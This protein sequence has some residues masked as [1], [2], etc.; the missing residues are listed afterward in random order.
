MG[1]QGWNKILLSNVYFRR[2]ILI[3]TPTCMMWAFTADKN[4]TNW[5]LLSVKDV[6]CRKFVRS[7]LSMGDPKRRWF[8]VIDWKTNVKSYSG[9]Y[10]PLANRSGFVLTNTRL[11]SVNELKMFVRA[12]RTNGNHNL[13]VPWDALA[14]PH[15]AVCRRVIQDTRSNIVII[16]F[17]SRDGNSFLV[18]S[19]LHR[20]R[21][22]SEVY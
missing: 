10:D 6:I 19:Y 9:C 20:L 4:R 16:T 13:V 15:R 3:C 5:K 12:T 2:K 8:P 21:V 18:V 17:L 7:Y 22:V 14:N 1:S 11:T